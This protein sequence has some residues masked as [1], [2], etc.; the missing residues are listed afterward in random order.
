[1]VEKENDVEQLLIDTL[2][3]AF[4]K[5]NERKRTRKQPHPSWMRGRGVEVSKTLFY[6]FLSAYTNKICEKQI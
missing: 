2:N 5:N 1:M 3:G 4:M 6:I